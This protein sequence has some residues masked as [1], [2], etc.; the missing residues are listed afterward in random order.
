MPCFFPFKRIRR[1]WPHK[2]TRFDTS[3]RFDCIPITHPGINLNPAEHRASFYCQ[4]WPKNLW[5]LFFQLFDDLFYTFRIWNWIFQFFSVIQWKVPWNRN[6]LSLDLNGIFF[7]IKLNY[8]QAL[9]SWHIGKRLLIKSLWD[10]S[11][12]NNCFQFL[13]ALSV[14]C[15]ILCVFYS[16]W[17]ASASCRSLNMNLYDFYLQILY[18]VII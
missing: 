9:I 2:P 4:P 16:W 15:L 8:S 6:I 17:L 1:K 12:L 13:P 3:V 5:M 18:F 10:E 11:L 14:W 7:Y